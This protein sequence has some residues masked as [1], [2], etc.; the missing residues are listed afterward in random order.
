MPDG[1]A[2]GRVEGDSLSSVAAVG[3]SGQRRL[4]EVVGVANRE[5]AEELLA[6][7]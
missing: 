7:S 3:E 2:A 1:E 5:S 6:L 4:L